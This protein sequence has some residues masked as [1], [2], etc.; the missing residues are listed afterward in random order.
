MVNLAIYKY[1][2]ISKYKGESNEVRYMCSFYKE[3]TRNK[4]IKSFRT[5]IE[6][7]D[8]AMTQSKALLTADQQIIDEAKK[9]NHRI[10]IYF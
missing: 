5:L 6:L 9:I 1:K 4:S 2:Y 10:S 3:C 8:F 7:L